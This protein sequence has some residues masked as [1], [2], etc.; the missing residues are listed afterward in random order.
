MSENQF[1][2]IQGPPGTGKTHVIQ[3][4]ISMVSRACKTGKIVVCTPSNV[5]VDQIVSRLLKN[6]DKFGF[7]NLNEVS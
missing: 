4:M 7:N 6:G 5:A 1:L 2:L 3:G